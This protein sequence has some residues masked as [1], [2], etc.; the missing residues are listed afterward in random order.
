MRARPYSIVERLE[1]P[2]VSVEQPPPRKGNFHASPS[3]PNTKGQAM[4]NF[5]IF[6]Y[7]ES[8]PTPRVLVA[9]RH[10]KSLTAM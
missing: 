10:N 5:H 3:Y 7:G 6:S 8:Y 9:I 2:Q 4:K 1:T